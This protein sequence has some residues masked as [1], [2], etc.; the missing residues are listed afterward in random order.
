MCIRDRSRA[1][2]GVL[3][4]QSQRPA[5]DDQIDRMR[6][7]RSWLSRGMGRSRAAAPQ[8]DVYKR[9]AG[10]PARA[11]IARGASAGGGAA[12]RRFR[13]RGIL[14]GQFGARAGA[15]GV[16]RAI[17]LA[18]NRVTRRDGRL[19]YFCEVK[20]SSLFS[21][22]FCKFASPSHSFGSPLFSLRQIW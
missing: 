1:V 18:P 20:R 15:G 14:H 6:D 10:N 4:A 5:G 13:R 3:H 8:K 11:S 17:I 22:A 9:Q 21:S 7:Y 12:A 19:L 16:A 2:R